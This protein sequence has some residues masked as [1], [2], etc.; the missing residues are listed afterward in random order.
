MDAVLR[1]TKRVPVQDAAA[2]LNATQGTGLIWLWSRR[3]R[4]QREYGEEI[5]GVHQPLCGRQGIDRLTDR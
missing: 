3:S 4:W 2:I 5:E 1:G